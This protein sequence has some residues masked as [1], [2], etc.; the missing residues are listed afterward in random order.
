MKNIFSCIVIIAISFFACKKSNTSEN[1]SQNV[2]INPSDTK[3]LVAGI[4]VFHSSKITA[5]F[6]TP[7]NSNTAPALDFNSDNQQITSFN[8]AIL[9]IHPGIVRG[10]V[11]GY[12]F[13]IN[14]S[15]FYYKV[16]FSQAWLPANRTANISSIPN[17]FL[18]AVSKTTSTQAINRVED[19]ADSA[20]NILLPIDLN[21]GTFCGQYCMYDDQNQVSNVINVCI[22]INKSGGEGFAG[23]WK[24]T[25]M[26]YDAGYAV[27]TNWTNLTYQ[28]E[29]HAIFDYYCYKDKIYA[30]GDQGFDVSSPLVSVPTDYSWTKQADLTFTSDGTYQSASATEHGELLKDSS[31]C[32]IYKYKLQQNALSN[33]GNWG[34]G[35]N[36]RTLLLVT[37]YL[38]PGTFTVQTAVYKME[39][40]QK[41]SSEFTLHNKADGTWFVY[42]RK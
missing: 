12:Y 2:P 26:K 1:S 39:I 14:N 18:S 34:I 7:T 13:K 9:K 11:A 23:T 4:K 37:E 28:K 17:P 16:D 22:V 42:Q 36:G 41:T 40:A 33:Q 3:A 32:S 27:D 29:Y 31:S 21:E 8:G 5:T 15:D 38:N 30:P 35:E 20:I 6:P 19:F 10:S 24:Q 25:A